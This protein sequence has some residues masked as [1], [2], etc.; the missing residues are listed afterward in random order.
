MLLVL[1]L[2]R[3]RDF[4]LRD[5][6]TIWFIDKLKKHKVNNLWGYDPIVKEK[7]ILNLGV[8]PVSEQGFQDADAVFFM[9]NHKSYSSIIHCF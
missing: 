1:P 2:R 8:K 5:S 9:N 4:D 6:T 3:T 7:D